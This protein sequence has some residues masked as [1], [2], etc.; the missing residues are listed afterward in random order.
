MQ[1]RFAGRANRVHKVAL[2]AVQPRIEQQA[3][4]ADDGVE[5][6]ADFVAH[7]GEELALGLGGG[8]RLVLGFQDFRLPLFALGNILDGSVHAQR[9]PVRVI[10]LTDRAQPEPAPARSLDLDFQIPALDTMQGPVKDCL[11][12]RPILRHVV[13][14]RR[15][16]RDRGLLRHLVDLIARARPSELAGAHI[17]FP[18]AEAGEVLR[19]VEQRLAGPQPLSRPVLLGD[20]LRVNRHTSDVA[21]ELEPRP[22]LPPQPL[23]A[24][25]RAHDAILFAHLDRTAQATQKHRAPMRRHVRESLENRAPQ[26]IVAAQPV[27]DQPPLARR[28]IAQLPVEQGH[29]RRRMLDKFLQLT[30]LGQKRLRRPAPGRG[31]ADHGHDP[32]QPVGRRMQLL[33]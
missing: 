33:K 17:E 24:T 8:E 16:H 20:H 26:Q 1:Q 7:V 13:T 11:H 27:I 2:L 9:D 23:L 14:Q 22:A 15:R 30:L 10:H 29:R 31:V 3:G 19:L 25:V 32:L 6:R 12:P 18:A 4:H 21:I 5:R 28:Q